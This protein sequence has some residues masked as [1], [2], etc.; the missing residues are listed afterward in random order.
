MTGT[1]LVKFERF[2]AINKLPWDD[3]NDQFVIQVL[4]SH[5]FCVK[6]L[7]LFQEPGVYAVF[8]SAVLQDATLSVKIASNMLEREILSVGS[9]EGL[10]G[11]S[12]PSFV[13]RGGLLQVSN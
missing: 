13:S 10:V 3:V 5:H 12:A 6:I 9:R 11:C 7:C 1:G 2:T 8:V 4:M